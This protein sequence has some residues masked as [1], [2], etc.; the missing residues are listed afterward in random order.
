MI[1][2]TA[3]ETLDMIRDVSRKYD[4]DPDHS[5]KVTD[6]SLDIFDDLYFLHYYGKAERR[7]LEM[8]GI[9]HDI[10][11]S[12]RDPR[13]HNKLSRD[14]ILG[15]YIPGLNETDK[16]ICALVARYHTGEL[17]D[18]NEH[19]HFASLSNNRQEVVE[20]LSAILRVADAFDCK[21]ADVVRK[22]TTEVTNKQI[23]FL[24]DAEG[25]CRRQIKRAHEKEDLLVKKSGRIIKYRC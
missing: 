6:F 23:T 3:I 17:P 7:L 20:W 11:Y 4:R 24:L 15:M 21:H 10:G 8:A 14:L 22:L 19:R 9:M 5:L 16:T 25:D 12:Q 18:A 2:Q 1:V 13:P